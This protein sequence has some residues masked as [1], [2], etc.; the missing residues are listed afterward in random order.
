M[1]EY[2]LD[3]FYLLLLLCGGRSRW[4]GRSPTARERGRCH[5]E[6]VAAGTEGAGGFALLPLVAQRLD[7]KAQYLLQKEKKCKK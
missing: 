4:D 7:G 3:I 6:A 2:F 1:G 5:G